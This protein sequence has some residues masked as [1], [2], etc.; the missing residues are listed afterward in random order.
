M[1]QLNYFKIILSIL[2]LLFVNAFCFTIDNEVDR[3]KRQDESAKPHFLTQRKNGAPL[4]DEVDIEYE[5][6]SDLECITPECRATAVPETA[7]EIP[8]AEIP[9]E[10][11]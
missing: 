8:E 2:L 10:T 3:F 7:S 1:S 6:L 11:E 4:P 9:E 5:N